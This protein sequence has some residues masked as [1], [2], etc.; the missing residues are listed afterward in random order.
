MLRKWL[1]RLIFFGLLAILFLGL[2]R[3]PIFR[4][5]ENIVSGLTRVVVSGLRPITDRTYVLFH[6]PWRIAQLAQ[7]V[8]NLQSQ[9]QT[10]REAHA[11]ADELERENAELHRALKFT[12]QA[13]HPL[14]ATRI[15]SHVR[16]GG[17]FFFILNRGVNDGIEV[18]APVIAGSTLIAKIVKVQ[19]QLSIAAPLFTASLKTAATFSGSGKNAGIVEGELN[20]SMKMTLI[21][22]D[23]A[24]N[25]GMTVITS[26][27]EEKVPRGLLI[28]TVA[29]TESNKEG[30]F[31]TAF[32]NPAVDPQE[33][34]IVSVAKSYAAP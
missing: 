2:F 19:S 26:G 12:E 25:A 3:L 28:G 4:P 9:L 22:K 15:I 10:L 5:L 23:I 8:H 29:R 33:V 13:R 20:T 14:I 16:E 31:Q 18:G 21:P 1:A 24:V 6:T 7:E 32:L 34:T 11:R 17:A 27:L 30:L